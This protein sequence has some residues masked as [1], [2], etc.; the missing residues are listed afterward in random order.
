MLKEAAQAFFHR[1]RLLP[2]AALHHLVGDVDRL[3]DAIGL[4]E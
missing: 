3:V 2:P 1:Y 4:G